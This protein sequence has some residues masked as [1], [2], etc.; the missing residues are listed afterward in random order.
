M[1][2]GFAGTKEHGIERFAQAFGT[3]GFIVLVHD[4]R[5]FGSSGG[6]IRGDIDPWRQMA[7][8]HVGLDRVHARRRQIEVA[9]CARSTPP[10]SPQHRRTSG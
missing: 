10:A 9:E 8:W 4:H 6:K 7:D 1:A 3:A 5:N 2:H